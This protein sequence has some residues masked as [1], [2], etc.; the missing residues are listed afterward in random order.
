MFQRPDQEY[1]LKNYYCPDTPSDEET[2]LIPLKNKQNSSKRT[3]NIEIF[4]EKSKKKKNSARQ[5]SCV[6]QATDGGVS[7]ITSNEDDGLHAT[8]LVKIEI[9]DM[10]KIRYLAPTEH[11]KHIDVRVKYYVKSED[12]KHYQT[13]RDIIYGITEKLA[14]KRDSSKFFVEG[15]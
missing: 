11:W 7:Y 6:G 12:D 13:T 3:N 1:T 10:Q 14:T 2:T 9:Y 15:K 4:F 8:H 5:T